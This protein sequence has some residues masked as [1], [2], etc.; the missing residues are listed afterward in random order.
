[1]AFNGG[2]GVHIDTATG[3]AVWGNTLF[4]NAVLGI[5]LVN[6]GNNDQA[7]PQE[8]EATSING[9]TAVIGMLES[10]PK[11]RFIIQWFANSACHWSGYG[12]GDQFIA[13]SDV[14]TDWDGVARF[15][16]AFDVDLSG[17]W[18]T[19]TATDPD[20]NTSQF[21]ACTE[22]QTPRHVAKELAPSMIAG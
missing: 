4:G 15:D 20:G 6:G 12:E 1:I 14:K 5:E 19:A 8:L 16:L 3:V 2:D 9:F 11:T 21:S 18:L 22:V 10:T 7:F 17:Q 13:R